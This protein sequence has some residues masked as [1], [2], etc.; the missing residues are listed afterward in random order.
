MNAAEG[1]EAT[2]APSEEYNWIGRKIMRDNLIHIAA[3]G[4]RS[5]ARLLLAAFAVV[6]LS[7]AAQPPGAIAEAPA[8]EWCDSRYEELQNDCLARF[9][10]DSS[11]VNQCYKVVLNWYQKCLKGDIDTTSPC[12]CDLLKPLGFGEQVPLGPEIFDPG[13]SGE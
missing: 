6:A 3:V 10:N 1:N 13:H 12:L 4:R 2:A 8:K 5:A 9:I 11:R 7:L